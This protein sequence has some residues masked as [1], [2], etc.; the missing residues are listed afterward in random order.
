MK[1]GDA[2]IF[3]GFTVHKKEK[4]ISENVR[5]SIDTGFQRRNS[6]ICINNLNPLINYKWN[7]TLIKINSRSSSK[8]IRN[9]LSNLLNN[10]D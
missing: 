7:T 1:A 2:I 5:Q 10:N 4:Y 6:P 3:T 9:K 8:Y